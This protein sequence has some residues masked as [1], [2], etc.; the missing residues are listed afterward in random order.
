M[1]VREGEG[2]REG[3]RGV[4]GEVGNLEKM[5]P[6]RPVGSPFHSRFQGDEVA[7][8]SSGH[9]ERCVRSGLAP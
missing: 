4:N 7:P 1:S 9:R 2:R 6:G 5:W 3:R 8:E